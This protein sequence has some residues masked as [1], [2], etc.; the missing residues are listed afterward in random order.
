MVEG[1][2]SLHE[3]LNITGIDDGKIF[4]LNDS[5]EGLGKDIAEFINFYKITI[6]INKIK[7]EDIISNHCGSIVYIKGFNYDNKIFVGVYLDVDKNISYYFNFNYDKEL[8][9]YSKF[10]GDYKLIP[11][12]FVMSIFYKDFKRG[13][14]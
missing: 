13:I 6:D 11:K 2:E 8:N 12:L 4:K 9:K 10:F 5:Y 14:K 3:F 1:E 7:K